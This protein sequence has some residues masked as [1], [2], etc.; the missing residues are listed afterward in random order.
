M[1]IGTGTVA[2]GL[3]TFTTSS[4]SAG[5]YYLTAG[6]GGDTNDASSGSNQIVVTIMDVPGAT[7]TTLTGSAASILP[8]GSVTLTAHVIAGSGLT[9]PG[10][11]VS[12]GDGGAVLASVTLNAG[13]ASYTASG[14]APGTHSFSAAYAGS[15][16][17]F[18][19]SVSNAFPVVVARAPVALGLT[20]SAGTVFPNGSVLMTATAASPSGLTPA[21]SLTFTDG[22]A[23]LATVALVNGSA[24]FTA[25]GLA[26]GS[27]ALGATLVP[28]NDFMAGTSSQV[29]LA[30]QDFALSLPGGSATLNAGTGESLP[31]TIAPGASGFAAFVALSCSGA[32]AQTICS[33][34]PGSLTP[35]A[36]PGTA[37]LTL[38]TTAR[39]SPSPG[40]MLLGLSPGLLAFRRHNRARLAGLL[41]ACAALAMLAFASGCGQGNFTG[42]AAGG[43]TPAGTY[44]LT[45]TGTAT[46]ATVLT[47]SSTLSLTVK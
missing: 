47:H 8:S 23:S 24:S 26:T 45:I 21:G 14:L 10:G 34:S 37:T 17:A 15:A 46:G 27:H 7:T 12:F 1:P 19:G 36:A 22:S 5:S 18:S 33:V 41:T 13:S 44:L 30:V 6:Y 39:P 32:P 40:W 9:Q 3:A 4:L 28:S 20:T 16:T 35:G 29:P 31:L 38:T 43:G 2:N 42:I 11:T 25:A